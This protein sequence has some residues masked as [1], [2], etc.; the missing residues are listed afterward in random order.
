MM[1]PSMLKVEP[2]EFLEEEAKPLPAAGGACGSSGSGDGGYGNW[3]VEELTRLIRELEKT[4][5]L[6]DAR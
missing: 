3:T 5:G 1:R 6:V 4:F 2:L